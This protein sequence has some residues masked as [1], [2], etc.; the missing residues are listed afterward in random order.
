MFKRAHQLAFALLFLS[1]CAEDHK[2]INQD[3][4]A[5]VPSVISNEPAQTTEGQKYVCNGGLAFQL[6]KATPESVEIVIEGETYTLQNTKVG[7]GLE[8][9]G[10]EY[11]LSQ[12]DNSVY[13]T[14]YGRKSFCS[15]Q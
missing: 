2:P 9:I 1:A 14:H 5:S 15:G 11:A 13:L 7:S 4:A 3:I 10:G 12:H 8:Y 6:T